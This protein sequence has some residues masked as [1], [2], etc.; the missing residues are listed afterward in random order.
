MLCFCV[1]CL[2]APDGIPR[3][4]EGLR[5]LNHVDMSSLGCGSGESLRKRDFSHDKIAS[6]PI[7]TLSSPYE[8]LESAAHKCLKERIERLLPKDY[9]F[10]TS[11]D[12]KLSNPKP[13]TSDKSLESFAL[14]P[15]EKFL[16][17]SEESRL[18]HVAEVMKPAI[19]N[20]SILRLW[21]LLK[22]IRNGDIAYLQILRSDYVGIASRLVC[23]GNGLEMDVRNLNILTFLPMEQLVRELNL[24]DDQIL[25]IY[26]PDDLLRAIVLSSDIPRRNLVVSVNPKMS[27]SLRLGKVSASE[28][29]EF[30]RVDNLLKHFNVEFYVNSFD[31]MLRE[32]LE[33]YHIED[34]IPLKQSMTNELEIQ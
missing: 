26:Q 2:L 22:T 11:E 14:A 8:K 1:F 20:F 4:V 34:G 3:M 23:F 12:K 19:S 9:F 33:M 5:F 28:L 30:M 32:R 25:R 17:I 31:P 6:Q 29:P 16:D 7:K 13:G 15:F 18:M 24:A 27:E 21:V 10:S